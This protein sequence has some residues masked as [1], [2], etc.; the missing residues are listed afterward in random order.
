MSLASQSSFGPSLGHSFSNPVSFETPVR[1]GPRHCGQSSPRADSTPSTDA[2]RPAASSAKRRRFMITSDECDW[3]PTG[4]RIGVSRRKG[5]AG[6]VEYSVPGTR[7]S[8]LNPVLPLRLARE[9]EQA[10]AGLEQPPPPLLGVA[11]LL[12]LLRLQ[13]GEVRLAVGAV[14]RGEVELD[15]G[16]LLGRQHLQQVGPQ[17]VAARAAEAVAAP[18]GADGV[19]AAV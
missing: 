17:L 7:Y 6:W 13:V 15:V 1:S 19:L 10:G 11:G 5:I 2:A 9:V 18:D 3:M 14:D 16:A 12:L 4:L 8:V